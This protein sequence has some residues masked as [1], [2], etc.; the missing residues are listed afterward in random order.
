LGATTA[1]AQRQWTD[2][3]VQRL[4]ELGWIEGRTVSIEYRWGEGRSE[5]FAEIAAEFIRLRVDVILAAGTAPAVA[6]H[7]VP[8]WVARA[9]ARA[10]S[11]NYAYQNWSARS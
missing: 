8:D 3:F 4:R 11:K 9:H 2:G 7:A 5:R 1:A 10:R 6:A